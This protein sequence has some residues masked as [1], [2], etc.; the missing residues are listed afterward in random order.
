MLLDGQLGLGDLY[1]RGDEAQE[2]GDNLPYVDVGSNRSAKSIASGHSHNCAI[3]DDDQLK[4]WGWNNYGMSTPPPGAFRQVDCGYVH[5][6][7]V[8]QDGSVTCW[9]NNGDGQAS[10]PNGSFQHVGT[11]H[12]HTCGIRSDG[13][14]VCWGA[15]NF[16]QSTPP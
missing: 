6:C 1:D 5:T 3:L 7:G 13:T 9:G 16:G 10:P 2:M 12:D 15:D 11:G 4:C 14:V 8:R